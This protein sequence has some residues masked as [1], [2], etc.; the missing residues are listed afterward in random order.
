[1]MKINVCKIALIIVI[2]LNLSFYNLKQA[3]P[4]DS[5]D[6]YIHGRKLIGMDYEYLWFLPFEEGIS[7]EKKPVKNITINQETEVTVEGNIG[8]DISINLNYNDTLPLIEQQKIFLNYKGEEDEFIKE[9]TLGDMQLNLPRTEFIT[10]KLSLL[11]VKIDA[12]SGD[13]TFTG[14]G[15]ISRGIPGSKSF[16]GKALFYKK[17]IFDTG[18]LKRKYYKPSL[19]L[20][21]FLPLSSVE[22]YIDDRDGGNNTSLT[23][24]MRVTNDEISPPRSYFGDFDKQYLGEDFIVDYSEGIIKFCKNIRENFVIAL[25]FYDKE[26]RRYPSSGYKMIKEEQDLAYEGY[27]IKNYYFLGA[28]EIQRENFLLRIF[29][30]NGNLV[31]S[32]DNPEVS[33]YRITIDYELGIVKITKPS[34]AHP[35]KPFPQAYPPESL[36]KYTIYAQYKHLVDIYLLQPDIIPGSEKVYLDGKLLTRKKD[37]LIDYSSGLLT[38]LDPSIKLEDRMIRVDYEWMPLGGKESSIL[39]I[40]GRYNPEENFSLGSTLFSQQSSSERKIP[41]IDSPPF[42]RKVSGIDTQF[43]FYPEIRL[44]GR[45]IPLGL[46]FSGEIAHNLYNPNTFGKAIVEDFESAKVSEEVSLD[47]DA[48]KRCSLPPGKSLEDRE[49]IE[50]SNERIYG[51]EINPSWSKEEKEIILFSYEDFR[52]WEGRVYLLSSSGRDYTQRDYL[53]L[54]VKKN[55]DITIHLDVGVISEDIDGDGILDTEDR[56]GDG[57]LNPGEDKGINLGGVVIGENNGK[58]DTEDLDGDG[59]LEVSD[60]FSSFTLSDYNC[61]EPSPPTGW[62]KYLIPLRDAAN[63]DLIKSKVKHLR[64]WIEGESVSGD[65]KF[66]SISIFG[67]RWK[68]YNLEVKA[69]NNKDDP[70]YNPFADPGFYEYYKEVYGKVKTKEEKWE[71]EGALSLLFNLEP[72]LEGWAEQIFSQKEDWSSYGTL[73]FWIYVKEIEGEGDFYLRF[74]SSV[75][76]GGNYYEVRERI[77]GEERKWQKISIP[78]SNLYIYGVPSLEEIKGI[79]VGISNSSGDLLQGIIYFNDIFLSEVKKKNRLAKRVGLKISLDENN[80][81]AGEYKKMEGGFQT[82]GGISPFEDSELSR[83]KVNICPLKYFPFSYEW[84]RDVF[85]ERNVITR[86]YKINYLPPSLPRINIE[87]KEKGVIFIDNRQK[88]EETYKA[89]LFF[90]NSISSAYERTKLISIFPTAAP[91]KKETEKWRI[92]F[93]FL[94]NKLDIS[95]L[96]IQSRVRKGEEKKLFFKK[97]VLDLELRFP[98]FHYLVSHLSFSG[99]C[100]EGNFSE[101]NPYRRDLFTHKDLSLKLPLSL[102]LYSSF[103]WE[104]RATYQ[105]TTSSLDFFSLLGLKE[106]DL[107]DGKI[108]MASD[109]TDFNFR[110][111]WPLFN[112]LTLE[113]G[114]KEREEKRVTLGTPYYVRM[115]TFPEVDLNFNLLESSLFDSFFLKNFTSSSLTLSFFKQNIFQE[116]ISSR[117]IHR[118]SFLWKGNLKEPQNLNL[119]LQFKSSKEEKNYFGEGEVLN[120]HSSFFQLKADYPL[121]YPL[122]VKIPLFNFIINLNEGVSLSGGVTFNKKRSYFSSG[123]INEN[124]S[125]YQLSFNIGNYKIGKNLYLKL[126]LSGVCYKDLLIAGKDYY[127]FGGKG[128]VEIRF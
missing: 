44:K 23:R 22:I 43:S 39:G 53:A 34:S 50:V 96:Y 107:K 125:K 85:S 102:N 69:I 108:K 122:R 128:E 66:A 62:C 28:Q 73:N 48:W 121:L 124:N 51:E 56:N 89:S 27:E 103:K 11:G 17:E 15:S 99:G 88:R 45:E 119:F 2:L 32:F 24:R 112:F 26:G 10:D 71:K 31:F 98:L 64:I 113:L 52:G 70:Q 86:D 105:E 116:K 14:L 40:R 127:S 16:I 58:L 42:F 80:S 60:N 76:E 95:P 87:K 92:Y 21:P 49:E 18:Y 63:W 78:L 36:H 65:V 104:K 75:E 109:K 46:H 1:M 13:F 20:T 29:D 79:R 118:S 120:N 35:D 37:Y 115:I 101:T 41:H 106:L 123:K 33:D 97:N 72:G 81:F 100:E 6:L 57:R 61:E 67:N 82:I 114:Y 19:D 9:I 110:G 38:F 91:E 90:P 7:S 74:G 77:N 117:N 93:P 8:K 5:P 126:G 59:R 3:H 12:R 68:E 25:A 84:K 47:K 55:E 30:M 83:I 4:E 111:K 54:W 94:F